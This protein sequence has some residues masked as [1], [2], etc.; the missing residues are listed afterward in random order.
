GVA[1]LAVIATLVLSTDARANGCKPDGQRCATNISC[2]SG[3][4]MKP[5]T[6]PGKAKPLFGVCGTPTTTTTTTTTSTTTTTM[7]TPASC[8][9]DDCGQTSDGCGGTLDCPCNT[10]CTVTCNNGETFDDGFCSSAADCNEH[11]S[12]FA[13]PCLNGLGGVRSHACV[14]CCPSGQV[15]CC[16]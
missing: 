15:T 14:P 3:Q 9:D 13:S 8:T 6:P 5:T 11:C 16:P 12:T 1:V 7:C 4:C 2:C 10:T